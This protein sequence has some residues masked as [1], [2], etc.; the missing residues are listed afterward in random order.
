MI[1]LAWVFILS[2]HTRVLFF[3]FSKNSK[4]MGIFQYFWKIRFPLPH[5][6]DPK[7]SLLRLLIS[8]QQSDF[9]YTC[10]VWSTHYFSFFAWNFYIFWEFYVPL[11]RVPDFQNSSPEFQSTSNA[12][13]ELKL[14]VSIFSLFISF[15][16]GFVSYF[17]H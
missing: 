13:I 6:P 17:E 14:N 12:R 9:N 11:L 1:K 5:G 16:G 3:E 10:C 15:F 7:Y 4:F 2:L 8:F